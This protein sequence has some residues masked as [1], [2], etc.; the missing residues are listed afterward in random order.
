MRIATKERLATVVTILTIFLVG[1]AVWRGHSVFAEAIAQRKA[2]DAIVRDLTGQ[3][4]VTLEY[5]IQRHD[6]ARSQWF[7]LSRA[8]DA[9]LASA[10]FENAHERE[11]AA[12]IRQRRGEAKELFVDLVASSALLRTPGDPTER[13]YEE[14]LVNRLLV[15]QQENVDDL[16]H[17]S[18]I[19]GD[20][21]AQ[22][23][24][25][26]MYVVLAGLAIFAL[27]KLGASWLINS[28]MLR[29]LARIGRVT[30][31]IAAGDWGAR[32]GSARKDEI[33]D[34]SR[35]FDAMIDELQRSFAQIGR[36]NT[37]LA[38]LNQ[39]LE[40]FSYSVSHDL[41]GPLRSLD[42]FSLVLE[43]D[44]GD[45][46]DDEGRDA[47]RRIRLASQRM[48]ELIEDLLRLSRVTRAD[49][50]LEPVDLGNVAKAIASSLD[51]TNPAR[52]VDWRIEENMIVQADKPLMVIAL[53]NLLQNAWKFTGKSAAPC[54]R[55]G[56]SVDSGVVS[57]FVADNGVG[58]DMVHADKLFSAFERLHHVDEF[59]GSGIGLAIVERII[60]R[61]HG[62]LGAMATA[63]A[64]A[65][66]TFTLGQP[67]GAANG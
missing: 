22:A 59:P 61:H 11:V 62:H 53:Q 1:A 18:G 43:E 2:T 52:K 47:L 7:G 16:L 19:V 4:L 24:L 57:F 49:L 5:M 27:M 20:R 40:A 25:D 55:M 29:P 13:R 23:Q 34:L 44:Y 45:R 64:G 30:D 21:I 31:A 56:S 6:R 46:L 42:G 8:L 37:D 26:V 28:R 51:A 35:N 63:G 39:E 66:F 15:K 9:K 50:R 10:S 65:T 3:Q 54:I 12:R 48:S 17:L 67:A 14:Q 38:T 41:R 60:R 33:G 36:N 58:F 32:L